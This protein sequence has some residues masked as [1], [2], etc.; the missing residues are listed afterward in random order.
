MDGCGERVPC[1]SASRSTDLN[2]NCGNLCRGSSKNLKTD[3]HHNSPIP[4]L[5]IHQNILHPTTEIL[6]HMCSLLYYLYYQ[7]PENGNSIDF[8]QLR[9]R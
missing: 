8:Y 3:V 4:L 7:W 2:T 5:G 6:A 9:N 1:I